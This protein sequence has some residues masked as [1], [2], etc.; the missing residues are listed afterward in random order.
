[1]PFLMPSLTLNNV[2]FC[3]MLSHNFSQATSTKC[4][5]CYCPLKSW[6]IRLRV[7]SVMVHV[8]FTGIIVWISLIIFLNRM[9]QSWHKIMNLKKHTKKG[10]ILSIKK[11]GVVDIKGVQLYP[12]EIEFKDIECHAYWLTDELAMTPYFFRS[13]EECDKIYRFMQTW[14]FCHNQYLNAV[15]S[16]WFHEWIKMDG[17]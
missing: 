2:S 7:S 3:E 17:F 16:E 8:W 11:C 10:N 15:H 9:L 4:P 12:L 1:M 14:Y 6:R 5:F 13:E